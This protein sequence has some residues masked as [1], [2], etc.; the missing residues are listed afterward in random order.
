MVGA[1]AGAGTSCRNTGGRD[2]TSNFSHITADGKTTV[3]SGGDTTI[4]DGVI[5][6]ECVVVDVVVG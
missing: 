5:A 2:L 4:K 1:T 6:G 3:A